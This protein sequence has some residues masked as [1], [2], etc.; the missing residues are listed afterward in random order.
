MG[1]RNHVL[2]GEGL[3]S[4]ESI[5]SSDTTWAFSQMTSALALRWWPTIEIL[6]SV[7]SL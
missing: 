4:N 2:D 6:L 5:D 1:P 3:T 7:I